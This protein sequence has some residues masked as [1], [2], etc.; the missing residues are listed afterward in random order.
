MTGDVSQVLQ[1]ALLFAAA[2]GAV[3]FI[4]RQF[5]QQVRGELG[6]AY[7]LAVEE[8]MAEQ[9]RRAALLVRLAEVREARM[10]RLERRMESGR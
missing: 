10:A 3:L 6:R 7:G 8:Q 2:V 5:L 9:G 1:N 4:L